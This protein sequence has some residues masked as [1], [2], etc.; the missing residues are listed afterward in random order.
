MLHSALRYPTRRAVL[1][2]G[3]ATP[4]IKQA[5]A[6]GEVVLGSYGGS[7]EQFFR[8]H[9]LPPFEKETGIKVT[10]VAGT[11]LS[12]LS[13]VIA[14]RARPELDIN[15]A[16]DLTHAAAIQAGLVDKINPNIVTSLN[17]LLPTARNPGDL[18]VMTQI[19]STGLQYNT[20]LFKRAGWAPPTSWLD[21]W[22]PKYKGK[23]AM[24]SIAILYSQQLLGLMTRLT[25]TDETNIG[26]ALKKIKQLKET[27]NIAVFANTPAELDNIMAQGQAWITYNG[28]VRTLIM[29]AAG[30]PMEFI[31]P[32]EGAIRFN[33][34]M[35]PLKGAPHPKEAQ[36]FIDFFLRPEIQE[37]CAE[38]LFYGPVNKAAKVPDNL[39]NSIP[40]GEKA[41]ASLV[42]LNS[43][44]M[45]RDLS[46]WIDQWNR[47]IES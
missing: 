26:P 33:L 30:A 10:Y 43:E 2:G 35:D 3:L 8:T 28:G 36:Q 39:A 47:A 14:T 21:L 4:F 18:G 46:D 42:Q 22:D 6:A 1:A 16:N 24:Y 34:I 44:V 32:K 19:A 41:I 27:G 9:V 13:K 12:N 29:R 17:E 31:V 45:N 20:E 38:N 40:Y 15:W 11:A 7:I 25:G 5:R 23:V 37:K